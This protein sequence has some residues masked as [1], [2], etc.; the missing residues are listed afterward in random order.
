MFRHFL[1]HGKNEKIF[2]EWFVHFRCFYCYFKN[3]ILSFNNTILILI[4]F[5]VI[6]N[7]KLLK[8]VILIEQFRRIV[9]LTF[10]RFPS[11]RKKTGDW[12]TDRRKTDRLTDNLKI[13]QIIRII[14]SFLF[15]FY[16]P[17][18]VFVKEN[19]SFFI[20]YRRK[21]FISN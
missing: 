13:E 10:L 19:F 18:Y 2:I 11:T 17:F 21:T 6:N 15:Q 8:N 14:D 9:S 7:K 16:T 3:Q 5:N 12:K 20:I 1:I 4:S